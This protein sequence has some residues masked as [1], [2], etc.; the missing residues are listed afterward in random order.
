MLQFDKW[1][2]YGVTSYIELAGTVYL[3]IMPDRRLVCSTQNHSSPIYTRSGQYANGCW[4]W[5]VY[6]LLFTVMYVDYCSLQ[7]RDLF[8]MADSCSKTP[9][10]SIDLD[11]ALKLLVW[12]SQSYLPLRLQCVNLGFY[13]GQL[14][15]LKLY[16]S[17][18]HLMWSA[19]VQ[20]RQQIHLKASSH[21]CTR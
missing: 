14:F 17:S 5:Y 16:F 19:P 1:S 6:R 20:F 2:L 15:C 18:A 13:S 21:Y 8:Q 10:G 7:M 4:S 11:S 3:T 12:T 9:C